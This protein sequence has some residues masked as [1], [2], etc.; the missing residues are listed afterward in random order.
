MKLALAP[1]ALAVVLAAGCGGSSS[2]SSSSS[3]L[4][5]GLGRQPLLGDHDLVDLGPDGRPVAEERQPLGGRPEEDDQR[6][7]GRHQ[8][9]LGRP[10]RPRQAEHGR[11]AAGEGRGRSALDRDQG[12]R[13]QAAE[14]GQL[15]GRIGYEGRRHRRLEHRHHALDDEHPDRLG[16]LEAPAGRRQG[17][18]PA[19]LQRRPRLQE[20]RA[21]ASRWLAR[22]AV[23]RM[24][25]TSTAITVTRYSWPNSASTIASVR[26]TSC[27]G[28]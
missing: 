15:G 21:A 18:A 13:R 24:R 17:R 1:L 4:A 27:A 7:Q 20:A 11:R 14:L 22:I 8:H 23:P 19:G 28:V 26:P 9:V 3:T 2:S 16:G 10:E 6:D 5:E 25:E 12:R